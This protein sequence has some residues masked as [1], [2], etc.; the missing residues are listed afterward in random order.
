MLLLLDEKD[1]EEESMEVVS[2]SVF[3]ALLLSM[4]LRTSAC[5][6]GNHIQC[7]ISRNRLR[8]C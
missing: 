6:Q 7:I 5:P 1:L 8:G 2:E 3:G 4:E